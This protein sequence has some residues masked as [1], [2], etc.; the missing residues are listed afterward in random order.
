MRSAR[1]IDQSG[2][3]EAQTGCVQEPSAG[4]VRV[5][6][7]KPMNTS[8]C[9]HD[10]HRAESGFADAMPQDQPFP[11]CFPFTWAD[12]LDP[13]QMIMK[14]AWTAQASI[15]AGRQEICSAVQ[16][17][18]RAPCRQIL[19]ETLRTN[20]DQSTELALGHRWHDPQM[21]GQTGQRWGFISVD[22]QE[23]DGFGGTLETLG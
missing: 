22:A 20:A 6:E 8:W 23:A 1:I 14:P 19:Q 12:R 13:D 21:G 17:S 5:D 16:Q 9:Q 15:Q 10:P 3:G 11:L 2:Q 4:G 7:L 18:T